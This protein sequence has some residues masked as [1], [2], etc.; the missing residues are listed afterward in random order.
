METEAGLI[1]PLIHMNGTSKRMLLQQL[2]DAYDALQLAYDALR[3]AS[4][5]GRDYY[6]TPGLYAKAVAQHTKRQQ[7]IDD[8]M[9]SIQSE[10]EEINFQAE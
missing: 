8:V 4:P 10:Y 2:E 1:V 5:N 9:A 6:H 7:A 3:Q